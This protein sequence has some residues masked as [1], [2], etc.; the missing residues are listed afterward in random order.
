MCGIEGFYSTGN[1]NGKAL[2]MLQGMIEKYSHR[3]SDA[4]G[5]NTTYEVAVIGIE[6]D[7]LGEAVK[8]YI[9]PNSADIDEELI[10]RYQRK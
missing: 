2:S 8:A 10:R 7:L 1:I 3:G 4:I 5:Y 6:D 9:V